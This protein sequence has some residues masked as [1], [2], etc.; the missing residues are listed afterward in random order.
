[1]TEIIPT[2]HPDVPP[3]SFRGVLRDQSLDAFGGLAAR[4][5]RAG[6]PIAPGM[7]WLARDACRSSARRSSFVPPVAGVPDLVFTANAAIV[8]DRKA[9]AG[10]VSLSAAPRGG[11]PLQGGVPRLA[12]EGPDRFHSHAAGGRH[13]RRRGRLR[14]RSHAQS[15]L[16]G[17]WPALRHRR[18]RAR[19]RHLRRRGVAARTRRSALLS[20]GHGALGACRMARSCMCRR[21]SRPKA[22]P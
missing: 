15:V 20:H 11:K 13:P 19:R 7:G 4:R 9:L 5:A 12:G 1:M 18:A 2:A 16:D 21:R 17:L 6:R 8:L 3:R 10:A 14:V 22:A